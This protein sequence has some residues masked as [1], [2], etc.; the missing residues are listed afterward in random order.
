M[1]RSVSVRAQ[2][3]SMGIKLRSMIEHSEVGVKTVFN[4]DNCAI[5]GRKEQEFILTM[6][7]DWYEAISTRNFTKHRLINTNYIAKTLTRERD[8]F[9]WYVSIDTVRSTSPNSRNI[10]RLINTIIRKRRNV[11]ARR[12]NDE[13]VDK[14]EVPLYYFSLLIL[15]TKERRER[16]GLRASEQASNEESMTHENAASFAPPPSGTCFSSFLLQFSARVATFISVSRLIYARAR[17]RRR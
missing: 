5:I 8:N 17:R 7:T 1:P 3:G 16:G 14:H 13:I 2:R 12:K 11:G 6:Y 9:L 15:E 10:R 4:C